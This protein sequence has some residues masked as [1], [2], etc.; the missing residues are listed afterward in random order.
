MYWRQPVNRG[1][2]GFVQEF[3]REKPAAQILRPRARHADVRGAQLET[4]AVGWSKR[5][6]TDRP[7]ALVAYHSARRSRIGERLKPSFRNEMRSPT[8]SYL[9]TAADRE[10][11]M[12]RLLEGTGKM[13]TARANRLILDTF[14]RRTTA[15]GRRAASRAWW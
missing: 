14:E 13:E 5:P 4:A 8:P 10:A 15:S 1:I 6:R 12:S 3:A 2:V 11:H 7:S 9:L